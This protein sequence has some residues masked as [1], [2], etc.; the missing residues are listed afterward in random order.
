[1]KRTAFAFFLAAVVCVTLG[2]LWGIE[3]GIREDFLLAPAHAHLNLVGWV[4]MAL[5]GLYY[6]VTPVAAVQPLA[7]VHLLVAIAGVVMF[8][9]GI[10]LS[11]LGVTHGLAIAG[12][13]VTLASML[14][15]LVTVLRHGL[16][17]QLR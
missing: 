4:S 7:R 1:M 17:P 8:V 12:S 6:H 14:I 11:I 13:L 3:M 5:F 15:F 2:M 9:P 16:G 10:A